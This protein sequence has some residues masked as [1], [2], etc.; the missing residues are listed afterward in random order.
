MRNPRVEK[1]IKAVDAFLASLKGQVH[2][3]LQDNLPDKT[4]LRVLEAGCGSASQ[5]QVQPDWYLTGIDL[6]ERQLSKNTT[7]DEKILGD[8]ETR[9]W[10]KG[11]FDLIICWDVLEHLPHPEK[12]LH[13]LFAALAPHGLLVLAFPN[14]FSI[15]GLV[16]KFTPFATAKVFYR[17]LIGEKRDF[18]ELNQFPTYLRFAIRPRHVVALAQKNGLQVVY[19]CIYEGP[20]QRY[21]RA[22]SRFADAGFA[23]AG[24]C[25][26]GLTLGF[27]RPNR[28]DCILILRKLQGA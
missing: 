27:F 6:S 26:K 22:L 18:Y 13:N 25:L 14:V 5:I 8:L 2:D 21:F 10:E 17:Y 3:V 12:A 19:E 23:V 16:T 28:T 9:R 15:K 4:P 1:R 20:V 11:S 7:L 24:F